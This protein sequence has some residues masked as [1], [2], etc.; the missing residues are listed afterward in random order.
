[1][2]FKKVGYAVIGCGR[3][4]TSHL[5]AINQL[6]EY[7]D[8]I[9][10]VDMEG[11]RAE[12]YCEEFGAKKYYTSVA[13]VLNDKAVEAV[14]LCLPPSA[15]CPIAVQSMNAGRHVLVEKPMC[16]TVAEA[17]EMIETADKNGVIL[18][19]GQSRRF[20]DP[21]MSARKMIREGKIGKLI[22]I[23]VAAGGKSEQ[24]AVW[25]WKD[26]N[27]TG[28]SNLVANWSSH[29][30]DQILWLANKRPVRVYAEGASHNYEFAG[31]DEFAVVIGFENGLMC[32]YQHSY[33]A[34]FADIGGVAY[35][36]EKGTITLIGSEVRLNGEKIEGVGAN[37]N[38]FTA[39]IKEFVTAIR[40]NNRQPM[41]S[42][43]EIRPV[44]AVMEAIMKSAETHEVI[45]LS[46]I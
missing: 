25:W 44:I 27:V 17:D 15:H 14:D 12:R 45:R 6:P 19:C 10:T 31:N 29:Y 40:E 41:A 9:A 7:I 5:K 28:P 36:G 18:M 35:M 26:A 24:A 8:L 4:S 2:G 22:H 32:S 20:N 38:N 16:L 33:N 37:V 42:G 23:S 21:L 3:I 13:D 39:E 1:M 34:S 30:I 11:Y 46:E 43:R